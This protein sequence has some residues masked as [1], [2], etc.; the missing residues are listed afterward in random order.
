MDKKDLHIKLPQIKSDV[1]KFL[2][3]FPRINRKKS[4]NVAKASPII[5]HTIEK[6]AYLASP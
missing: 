5:K 6:I 2:S 3:I 1:K 4:K